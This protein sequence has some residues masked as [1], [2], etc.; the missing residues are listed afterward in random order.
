MNINIIYQRRNRTIPVSSLK[1]TEC[2]FIARLVCLV[3]NQ[4]DIFWRC[5]C[6]NEYI[7]IILGLVQQPSHLDLLPCLF[8]ESL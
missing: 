6:Q 4:A 1:L 8:F 5:M 3:K 7:K 2:L